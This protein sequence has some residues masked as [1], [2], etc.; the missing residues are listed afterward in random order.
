MRKA[1]KKKKAN[2]KLVY[3]LSLT[4]VP[5]YFSNYSSVSYGCPN[6]WLVSILMSSQRA[7]GI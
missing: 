6:V 1:K 7:L 5:F 4:V 3:S 2:G